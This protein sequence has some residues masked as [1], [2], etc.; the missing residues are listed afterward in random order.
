MS[1]I[2]SENKIIPCFILSTLTSGFPPF[3]LNESVKHS[4]LRVS[5][6]APTH[7]RHAG[8]FSVTQAMEPPYSVIV[9]Q[10]S[11]KAAS[12]PVFPEATHEIIAFQRFKFVI[13]DR[14]VAL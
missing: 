14:S 10:M 1:T 9:W 7:K 4:H 8:M 12:Y 5:F 13:N 3:T 11:S 6:F 2:Y